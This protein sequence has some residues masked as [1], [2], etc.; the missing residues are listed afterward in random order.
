M[1]V[2]AALLESLVHLR[3]VSTS[4][5]GY[6][7]G[8]QRS[9]MWVIK[10]DTIGCESPPEILVYPLACNQCNCRVIDGN[11]SEHRYAISSCPAS[12]GPIRPRIGFDHD[13]WIRCM[14]TLTKAIRRA[15][16]Q[17]SIHPNGCCTDS[18]LAFESLQAA[19]QQTGLNCKQAMLT[20]HRIDP[21]GFGLDSALSSG[22]AFTV[23]NPKS[24][25][26]TVVSSVRKILL[27]FK[28]LKINE[29]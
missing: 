23:A 1:V 26:F 8:W 21:D 11:V 20:I 4:V 28:S 12:G 29:N 19:K 27:D 14:A 25:I 17:T 13:F 10:T 7:W 22:R 15:Q 18:E 16:C 6:C 9:G 24:P 2:A 3:I 5:N